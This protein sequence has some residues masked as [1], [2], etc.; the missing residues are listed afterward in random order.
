MTFLDDELTRSF[1]IPIVQRDAAFVMKAALVASGLRMRADLR[2]VDTA[3]AAMLAAACARDGASVDALREHRRQSE[4][5]RAL[6]WLADDCTDA[7]AVA[8]RRVERYFLDEFRQPGGAAWAVR[9]ANAL[10]TRLDPTS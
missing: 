1:E 3:D 8:P 10:L 6:R 2:V 5:R 7:R 9:A 4:V